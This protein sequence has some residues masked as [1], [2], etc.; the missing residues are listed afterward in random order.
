MLHT[1]DARIC[2]IL[3]NY[4]GSA[5]TAKCV[6]SLLQSEIPV[7]TVVVDS[8]PHDPELSLALQF[9]PLVHILDQLT[10]LGFGGANNAGIRFALQRDVYDFVFLLNNDTEVF[11]QTI[12]TLLQ[13]MDDPALALVVPRIVYMDDP[14]R[15]WY[16]G[17][18]IDWKRAS[19]DVPNFNG[20]AETPLAMAER[21]V[22]FV[23]GCAMFFRRSSLEALGGFD[24]RYFMYEEDVELSLKAVSLGMRLRY[25][26]SSL[27]LHKAQG[28]T[29]SD[30]D[31][32]VDFWDSRSAALPFYAYH[33]VRNRL[34]TAQAYARGLGL[35][36][37]V[38]FFPLYILRR[39]VPFVRSGRLDAIQAMA[40]GIAA[41]YRDRHR[42]PDFET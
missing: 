42:K 33:I 13:A 16:G 11:P 30:G 6:R 18:N 3:V 12:G 2:V 1:Q 36:Q 19:A 22:T 14:G 28:S 26:P 20:N 32:R 10:N 17:G 40:R 37:V 7:D 15:L 39:A 8:T 23:T 25:I 9:A 29:R 38:I 4:C 31:K 27:L 5:D 35:L 24:S 41:A 21:D 34:L